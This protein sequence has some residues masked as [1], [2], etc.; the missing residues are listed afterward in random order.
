MNSTIS[1]KDDSFLTPAQAAEILGVKTRQLE[2]WRYKRRGPCYRRFS[3][4]I[5]YSYRD[6]KTFA[7]ANL[8]K[9]SNSRPGGAA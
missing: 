3:R 2:Y 7:E 5:R 4:S 9:T 8:V 6:L 1:R